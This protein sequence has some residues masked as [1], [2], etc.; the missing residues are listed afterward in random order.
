[1]KELITHILINISFAE[2]YAK[3]CNSYKD[4]DN[5][6]NFTKKQ[7]EN[8]LLAHGADFTYVSKEKSFYKDYIFGTYNA[9]VTM[10]YKYGFVEF[11]YSFWATESDEYF[12][13][14]FNTIASTQDGYFSD[15]VD[16]NFPI[17][18]SLVGLENILKGLIQLNSE[19]VEQLGKSLQNNT[20]FQ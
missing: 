6:M 16:Y 20:P 17:A 9:R 4:Y 12:M 7:V 2:R 13:G 11:F 5:G 19:F 18:T 15:K 1:M 14:R 3:I 8:I 10:T